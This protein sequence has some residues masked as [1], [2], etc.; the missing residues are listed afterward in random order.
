MRTSSMKAS[1]VSLASVVKEANATLKIKII[2]QAI[3]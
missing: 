3:F 1:I 2:V